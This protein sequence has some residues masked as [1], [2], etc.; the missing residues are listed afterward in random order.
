MGPVL[1]VYPVVVKVVL[2]AACL[3]LHQGAQAAR[4]GALSALP[5]RREA[6]VPTASM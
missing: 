2:I 3:A 4:L 1:A 6:R 5:A